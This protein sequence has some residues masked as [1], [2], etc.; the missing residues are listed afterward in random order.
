MISFFHTLIFGRYG[1]FGEYGIFPYGFDKLIKDERKDKRNKT[2]S[3]IESVVLPRDIDK[4][5]EVFNFAKSN[6]EYEDSR[7]QKIEQK[8]TSFLGFSTLIFSTSLIFIGTNSPEIGSIDKWFLFLALFY[9]FGS[10]IFCLKVL[11]RDLYHTIGLEDYKEGI[12]KKLIKEYEKSA[13]C[14]SVT[15]S[16][17]IDWM[18]SAHSWFFRFLL[19]SVLFL[20]TTQFRFTQINFWIINWIQQVEF[21]YWI[22]FGILFLFSLG[23]I[24]LIKK[25]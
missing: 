5:K 9:L 23:F 8:T 15:I 6:F 16:Q 2:K 25:V 20:I 19:S 13:F 14:N 24:H 11:D 12:T 17:K 18:S 1:L 3:K 21:Q 10:T 7:L 22:I 4:L